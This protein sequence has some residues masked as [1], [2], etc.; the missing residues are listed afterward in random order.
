MGGI[1]QPKCSLERSWRPPGWPNNV[2]Y[3]LRL[4]VNSV[5]PAMMDFDE[6]K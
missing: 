3:Y 1:R 6:N 5:P 4:D 2:G